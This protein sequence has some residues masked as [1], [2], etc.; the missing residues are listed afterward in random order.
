MPLT[1]KVVAGFEDRDVKPRLD[2]VLRGSQ[3]ARPG[4]NDRDPRSAHCHA[5][6]LPPP[7]TPTSDLGAT[8][9]LARLAAEEY[10]RFQLS[11]RPAMSAAW[12]IRQ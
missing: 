11:P 4:A 1:S 5:T 10:P 12:L 3:P 2:C 8:D 9:V 6:S 7:I